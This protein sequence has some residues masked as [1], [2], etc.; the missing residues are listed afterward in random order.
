MKPRTR[1]PPRVNTLSLGFNGGQGVQRPMAAAD[2]HNEIELNF[3]E[4]GEMQFRRGAELTTLRA[5]TLIIYWAAVPHQVLTVKPGTRISWF[6]VPLSW[7]L[8][9][10]LSEAF[11]KRL[12]GERMVILHQPE[13]PVRFPSFGAWAEDF[14]RST[15]LKVAVKLELEAFFRR[16]AANPGG[17]SATSKKKG[18]VSGEY[19]SRHVERMV[20]LITERFREPLSIETIA[21]DTGLNPEYAMRLFRT[22]WGVTLW[23]FLLQQ[24]I[25][26]AR[27][28]LLLG[29]ASVAEIAFECG[30]QSL[31]RFYHAFK[32]Q[33]GCSPGAYRRKY[34]RDN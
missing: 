6:V 23:T 7:F 30:F 16:L 21:Q 11:T 24:R 29:E 20:K 34:W 12:L 13:S 5:G 33:C 9:W 17:H 31:G 10:K 15:E 8:N 14:K 28:L 26:E 19:H 1:T 2:Q 3:V 22:R 4:Q 27:R 18:T 32:T 25:A